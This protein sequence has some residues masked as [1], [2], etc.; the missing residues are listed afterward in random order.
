MGEGP[1]PAPP[2]PPACHCPSWCF[3]ESLSRSPWTVACQ[4]SFLYNPMKR[5]ADS[6]Q[7]RTAEGSANERLFTGS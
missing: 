2:P 6:R 4:T 5:Y 1:R 7:L 3:N